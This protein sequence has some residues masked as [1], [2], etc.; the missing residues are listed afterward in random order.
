MNGESTT[1][2]AT[3]K[4]GVKYSGSEKLRK[5]MQINTKNALRAMAEATLQRSRMLAPEATGSLKAD[6]R[7]EE[8]DEE[9]AVA[10]VYGSPEVRYARRRH[11]ENNLHPDTKYYLQNAGDVV[12]K[13][14]IKKFL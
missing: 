9:N 5:L 14:G 6:G 1:T 11:Y 2:L 8:N 10:V 3:I 12:A 13:E 4:V 7:V